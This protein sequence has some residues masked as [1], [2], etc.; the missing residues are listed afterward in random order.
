VESAKHKGIEL[1]TNTEVTAVAGE[2]GDFAVTLEHKPWYVDTDKCSGCGTCVDACPITV[3]HGWEENLKPR[4]AIYA[5]FP[6]AAPL[7]Y[8]IDRE[9]CVEC[10]LC[11]QA[12]L[13][14]AI[15]LSQ[16]AHTEEVGVGAIVLATGGKVFD[17]SVIPQFHYGEFDNVVTNMEFERICN[18]G[19]P[20]E[21]ELVRPDGKH[22]RSVAFVQCVGSRDLRHNPWCSF[23][24]CMASVK[25]GRL[26]MEHA[27][28]AR[29]TVFFNDLR[30]CGKGFEELY[31]R[32]K[33]DGM[34]F[35]RAVPSIHLNRTTNNPIVV[36]EDS[37]AGAVVREEVDL[38]VLASGL[39]PS[40]GTRKL[41]DLLGLRTDSYGFVRERHPTDG[42]AET[43]REGIFTAGVCQGP[44]DIPDAATHGSAAASKVGAFL[45]SGH[46]CR[47]HVMAVAGEPEPDSRK[48]V[49]LQEGTY[50]DSHG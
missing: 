43:S 22:I 50:G 46:S 2:A 31:Q 27:P 14:N 11:M 26:V 37:E 23:F 35:V 49:E 28:G 33:D 25:G 40:D 30:A 44:K 17:P 19:G 3:P 10:G 45:S 7:K 21:G 12:C 36:Y 5:M 13:L 9:H 16:E 48:S 1:V 47:M 6:Q 24:C 34:K 20:T 39:E 4:K 15:D 42:M 29:V 41:S 8:V 38:V 32:S 18:A